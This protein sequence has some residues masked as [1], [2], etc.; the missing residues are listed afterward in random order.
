[1]NIASTLPLRCMSR[2]GIVPGDIVFPS[3]KSSA[4]ITSKANLKLISDGDLLCC[5]AASAASR[6]I[7]L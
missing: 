7:R 6:Q 3:Q 1:M 5:F 2:L 4:D